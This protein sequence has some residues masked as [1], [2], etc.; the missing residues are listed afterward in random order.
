VPNP[1]SL[2]LLLSGDAPAPSLSTPAMMIM[3]PPSETVSKFPIKCFLY[4][5]CLGHKGLFTAV[6]L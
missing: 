5:G 6:E 1:A 3:D 2:C 4:N